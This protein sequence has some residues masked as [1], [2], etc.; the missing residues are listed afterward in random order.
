MAG[1]GHKPRCGENGCGKD[2]TKVELLR[3]HLQ[4]SHGLDHPEKV[5]YFSTEDEFK[6]WKSEYQESNFVDFVVQ[7]ASYQTRLGNTT[8]YRC[9][10]SYVRPTSKS[11]GDRDIKYTGSKKMDVVCTCSLFVTVLKNKQI[12]VRLY[13]THYNHNL[14]KAHKQYLKI[15]ESDEKIF[16]EK[17]QAGVPKARIIQD[18]NDDYLH[19][20]EDQAKVRHFVQSWTIRNLQQKLGGDKC[21]KDPDDKK[22]VEKWIEEN[23]STFIYKKFNGMKDPAYPVSFYTLF[24]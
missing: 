15:P 4:H 20:T 21:R 16:T 18:I 3:K 2:F 8:S 14:D 24:C 17:L 5:F 12:Y 22:S 9:S 13:P 1:N 7:K 11:D 6:S 23:P 10:R 19:T